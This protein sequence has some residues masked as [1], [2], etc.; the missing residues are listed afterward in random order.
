[1]HL[2]GLEIK[3]HNTFLHNEHIER[4]S[5]PLVIREMHFK[6]SMKSHSTPTG[7][8][9]IKKI[10]HNKCCHGCEELE[11]SMT[12]RDVKWYSYFGKFA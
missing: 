6:I 8:T 5:A 10:D 7:M 12:G 4:C 2:C 1:M 3:Q 11:P 9:K